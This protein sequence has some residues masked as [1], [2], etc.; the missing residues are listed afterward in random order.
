MMINQQPAAGTSVRDRTFIRMGFYPTGIQTIQ[1]ILARYAE[2]VS[3]K[4]PDALATRIGEQAAGQ[5]TP[6]QYIRLSVTEW[7][8]VG[9]AFLECGNDQWEASIAS[10]ISEKL[11]H[12]G[13]I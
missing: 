7:E 2:R 13:W 4:A 10:E 11:K 8:Q 1:D 3:D 12:H 5:V 9:D 6:F